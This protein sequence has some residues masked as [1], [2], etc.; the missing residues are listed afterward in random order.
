MRIRNRRT[1]RGS[2]GKNRGKGPITVQPDTQDQ[3]PTDT[4]EDE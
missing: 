3:P 2:R 1:R 4:E